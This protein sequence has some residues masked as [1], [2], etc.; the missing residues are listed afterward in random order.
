MK[1]EDVLPS[2]YSCR[3]DGEIKATIPEW[4]SSWIC[5]E[6]TCIKSALRPHIVPIYYTEAKV[7]M[8]EIFKYYFIFL[9]SPSLNV[10]NSK[11]LGSP[12]IPFPSTHPPPSQGIGGVVFLSAVLVSSE[13]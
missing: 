11:L 4:V 9:H 12:A 3:D 6:K 1:K 8:E 2:D 10:G 7:E 5:N 13:P